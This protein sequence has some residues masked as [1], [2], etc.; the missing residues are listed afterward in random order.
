MS[1]SD[2]PRDAATGEE[3]DVLL[4]EAVRALGGTRR[5]GQ[6]H[7]ARAVARATLF[8]YFGYFIGP[9][10]FGFIAGSLGLR[11]AFVFAAVILLMVPVLARIMAR[12]G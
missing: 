11:Y 6:H 5:E 10:G 9:P 4:D 2:D 12:R 3:L 7:M 8:G 1:D